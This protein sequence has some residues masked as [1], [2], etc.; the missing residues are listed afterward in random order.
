MQW[1]EEESLYVPLYSVVVN[2]TTQE[3]VMNTPCSPDV[4]TAQSYLNPLVMIQGHLWDCVAAGG[5]LGIRW[6]LSLC[7]KVN[8][9]NHY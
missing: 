2:L 1:Q 9:S 5:L 6:H 4:L 8:S 7:P 3:C